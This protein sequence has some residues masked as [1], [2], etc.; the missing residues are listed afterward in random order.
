MQE[1]VSHRQFYTLEGTE[2]QQLLYESGIPLTSALDTPPIFD[3]P[4][5]LNI[6][7]YKCL[8]VAAHNWLSKQGMEDIEVYENDRL[9]HCHL[10]LLVNELCKLFMSRCTA[11]ENISF[12]D[13]DGNR[14]EVNFVINLP[15]L[16]RAETALA[17]LYSFGCVGCHEPKI[18]MKAAQ[19]CKF[20]K[21]FYIDCCCTD[22]E[23]VATLIESQKIPLEGIFIEFRGNRVDL[24]RLKE[25]FQN[26]GQHLKWMSIKCLNFPLDIFGSCAKLSE[27]WLSGNFNVAP[28][29]LEKFVNF[30]FPNLKEIHIIIDAVHINQIITL[31]MNSHKNIE[32]IEFRWRFA[33]DSYNL[34]AYTESIINYCP[35]MTSYKGFYSAEKVSYLPSLF[36][37]CQGLTEFRIIWSSGNN[38]D[39]S[40]VLVRLGKV[41]PSKLIRFSLPSNWSCTAEALESFLEDCAKQLTK[42]LLIGMYDRTFEHSELFDRYVERN[43]LGGVLPELYT[44]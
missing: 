34:T 23:G 42:P 33:L 9:G 28:E 38:C 17:N 10:Y 6:L 1:V 39:I 24:P 8:Y 27:L 25:A 12:D 36:K 29:T 37:V 30:Q 26:K 15:Q 18:T 21:V 19:I 11:L 5:F 16:P 31:I 2:S 41:L 14:L 3:Y 20:I 43:V 35:L 44:L 4:A 22:N 13:P 40:E 32:I 7:E